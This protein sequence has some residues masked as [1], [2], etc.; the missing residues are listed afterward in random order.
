MERNLKSGVRAAIVGLL[1][2]VLLA[3]LKIAAGIAFGLLSV[4]ADG[5]NNLS[6]CGSGLVSLIS[7]KVSRKPPDKEHPYGHR[8]AEYVA[9]LIVGIF[10]LILAAELLRS[11]VESIVTGAQSEGNAFVY[12][13]LGLSVAVKGGMFCYYRSVGKRLD[14]EV[15]KA[16]AKDSGCDMLASSI[17]FVGI[18]CSSFLSFSPDG[19][20]GILV[21][22]FIAWEGIGVIR[23]ESSR[24]LGNAPDPALMKNL[25]ERI[26]GTNGV[27]GCHDLR[28]YGY[29]EGHLFATVHAE[30]DASQPPT[31]LHWILDGME[32]KILAETGVSL[33]A[34]LDPVDPDD[35]D[36]AEAEQRVRAAVEGMYEG[37]DVHDFR[38]VRGAK[39]KA[40]FEVGIPFDCKA[41]DGEIENDISRAVRLLGDW[42]PVVTVER[43]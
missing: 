26:E 20:L 7:M 39:V 32:R 34:H 19:Y 27:L 21:A 10:V 35:G 3:A 33:T 4:L 14:S 5:V 42:E 25:R 37:M 30:M 8:R 1:C 41:K 13:L 31:V 28:L 16:A 18:A 40:V 29:G 36:R 15:L 11:S 9:S 22:L 38:L 17:I 2:N 43:I 6:D 12:A 23:E 24:L